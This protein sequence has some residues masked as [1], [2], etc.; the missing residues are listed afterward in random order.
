MATPDTLPKL[1][2]RKLLEYNAASTA[3]SRPATRVKWWG[4]WQEF[5]WSDVHGHVKEIACGFASLGL[6]RGDKVSVV[7]DNRPYLY[8]SMV[9]AQALGA[10]PVPVYQDSAAE[11]DAVTSSI[12]PRSA[13][14][15]PRTRSRS[16]RWPRSRSDCPQLER[17]VFG[18]PARHAQLRAEPWLYSLDEVKRRGREF[19]EKNPDFYEAGSRQGFSGSDPAI[20][21]YTSGTTGKPKGVVSDRFDNMHD[22]GARAPPNSRA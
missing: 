4:I 9:A 8:W 11:R 15:S 14:W 13:S 17:V 21:N 7:G 2:V 20:I 3:P 1:L 16:T 5:T 19:I 22:H 10:V 18:D 12:T 6:K